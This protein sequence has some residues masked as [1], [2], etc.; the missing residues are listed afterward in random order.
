MSAQWPSVLASA[1]ESCLAFAIAASLGALRFGHVAV[2]D[3]LLESS[4]FHSA[5][6]MTVSRNYTALHLASLAGH[7]GVVQALL[8]SSHFSAVDALDVDHKSALFVA[9]EFENA[10]VMR[11]LLYSKKFTAESEASKIGSTALHQAAWLG[12]AEAARVLLEMDGF[13]ASA[14]SITNMYGLTAFHCAVASGS[15]ATVEVF[16]ESAKVTV[17]G[18]DAFGS[19]ALHTAAFKGHADIVKLLL[20]HPRVT[21]ASK[22]LVNKSGNSAFHLAAL[23]GHVAVTRALLQA[24]QFPDHVV[25]AGTTREGSTALHMAVD[26][27]HFSVVQ[28]LLASPRFLAV[29]GVTHGGVRNAL[30]LAATKARMRQCPCPYEQQHF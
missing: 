20:K 10:K 22:S 6:A 16:L 7:L 29:N 5:N 8:S 21:A 27:G 19:S 30:H 11:H 9:A 2:V 23:Q 1:M 26:F 15:V 4:R 14:V 12:H 17:N 28:M 18:R 24:E 25:N 13:P 3:A